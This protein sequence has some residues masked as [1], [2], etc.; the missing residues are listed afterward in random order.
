MECVYLVLT[1]AF[2]LNT[3]NKDSKKFVS[4]IRW[5]LESELL[6]VNKLNLFV[7]V[8]G[9]IKTAKAA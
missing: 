6:T 5:N 7:L 3:L 8:S 1:M 9:G 2:K 4:N